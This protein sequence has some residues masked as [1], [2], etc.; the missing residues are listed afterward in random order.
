[1]DAPRGYRNGHG[2]PQRLTLGSGTV[3]IRRP[4]V[5]GLQERFESRVLPLFPR[6]TKAA[7]DLLR[8][9]VYAETVEQAEPSDWVKSRPER[10]ASTA[11][12]SRTTRE[13]P[14][15]E[16]HSHTS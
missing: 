11:S 14:P 15:P 13:K 10:S 6:R 1:V 3:T 12:A 16:S 4:R 7:L 5:R 2:R 8:K 9:I